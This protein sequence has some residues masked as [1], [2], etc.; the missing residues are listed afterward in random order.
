MIRP[1][2]RCQR[3]Y[4]AK[5]RRSKYCSSSCRAMA[6]KARRS[7]LMVR[8]SRRLP[9]PPQCS[10][11]GK[12]MGSP[13][14]RSDRCSTC[15]ANPGRH[16]T[17][18]LCGEPMKLSS[19][20]ASTGNAHRDCRRLASSTCPDCAGVK[21]PSAD[22]CRRCRDAAQRIRPDDDCRVRRGQRERLAPGM[23]VSARDR[24]LARWLRQGRRCT[25]C[26]D[27]ADTI[28]HV[29]PLVRGGT[30]YEGNLV[31]ACRRCNSAKQARL[32][33]EWRAGRRAGRTYSP[34]RQRKPSRIEPILGEQG[35]MFRVCVCGMAHGRSSDYC[36]ERCLAR[37]KYRLKVG[38]PLGAPPYAIRAA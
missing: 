12:D 29:V 3:P 38:I 20:S 22:R 27:L 16:T 4:E 6:S 10:H 14:V 13:Y 31:P 21:H 8:A 37:S 15:R 5:T 28:D 30:N 1:C 24:L 33:A 35:E 34:T 7:P 2:D 26:D 32:L 17:C 25:Y 19:S 9:S 36:S 11:C 23:T 18:R